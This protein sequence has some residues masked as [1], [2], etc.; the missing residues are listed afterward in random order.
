[1]NDNNIRSPRDEINSELDKYFTNEIN[2]HPNIK[3]NDNNIQNS[4]DIHN[5]LF[6]FIVNNNFKEFILSLFET[7]NTFA[8]LRQGET[9]TSRIVICI[10]DGSLTSFC[11]RFANSFLVCCL[12]RSLLG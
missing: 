3:E 4:S 8:C 9:S 6:S 2:Y 11:K 7:K 5:E 12:I 10:K 1:M